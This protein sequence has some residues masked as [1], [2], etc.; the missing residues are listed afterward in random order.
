MTRDDI[1][2]A[3]DKL[4]FCVVNSA[5]LVWV[6]SQTIPTILARRL[7]IPVGGFESRVAHQ[8]SFKPGLN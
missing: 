5:S 8:F 2:V 1:P 4:L 7:W 3:A 6:P